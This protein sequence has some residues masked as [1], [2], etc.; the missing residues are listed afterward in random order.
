MYLI[1]ERLGNLQT[2]PSKHK[3]AQMSTSEH[4]WIECMYEPVMT[5]AFLHG[6]MEV[7]RTVQV[8]SVNF[9]KVSGPNWLLHA[10]MPKYRGLQPFFSTPNEWTG[11]WP[12]DEMIC[13]PRSQPPFS[14]SL[15]QTNWMNRL[16]L[17]VPST[18]TNV[19]PNLKVMAVSAQTKVKPIQKMRQRT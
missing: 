10:N 7:I 8:P 16:R 4:E 3:Q 6:R 2:D 9:T 18:P 15:N 14:C 1:Q 5:K 13:D 11:E 12:N 19:D 17:L